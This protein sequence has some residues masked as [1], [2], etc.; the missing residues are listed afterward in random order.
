MPD[1]LMEILEKHPVI[2]FVEGDTKRNE[3]LTREL[4]E[5]VEEYKGLKRV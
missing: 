4:K 5:I 3:E 1:A 2:T